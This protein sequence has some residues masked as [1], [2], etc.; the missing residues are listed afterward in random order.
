M[1]HIKSTY[2]GQYA[3]GSYVVQGH[4]SLQQ[5]TI[6]AVHE[7]HHGILRRSS[8]FGAIQKTAERFFARSEQSGSVF[9]LHLL[10]SNS[11]TSEEVHATYQSMRSALARGWNDQEAVFAMHPSYRMYY[12]IGT[13]LVGFEAQ[14]VVANAMLDAITRF[15]WSAAQLAEV[16]IPI[17]DVHSLKRINSASYPD[18][19][20]KALL[21]QWD[22]A[23]L[24]SIIGEA[25]DGDDEKLRLLLGQDPMSLANPLSQI[26]KEM[27]DNGMFVAAPD[28]MA[29]LYQYTHANL[30]MISLVTE[31]LVVN[32]YKA[33]TKRFRGTTLA[34]FEHDD[35]MR[36]VNQC[37][38]AEYRTPEAPSVTRFRN[39]PVTLH[40]RRGDL[41]YEGAAI[42]VRS[43][44]SFLRNFETSGSSLV[45]GDSSVVAY[46]PISITDAPTP[47]LE[48]IVNSDAVKAL[49]QFTTRWAVDS[50][51]I[52]VFASVIRK[53]PEVFWPLLDELANNRSY[54]WIVGDLPPRQCLQLIRSRAPN[55]RGFWHETTMP[56]VGGMVLPQVGEYGSIEGLIFLGRKPDV[57]GVILGIVI[58]ELGEDF[59]GFGPG[60][61]VQR[62]SRHRN[63]IGEQI[64][65]LLLALEQTS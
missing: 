59:R 39:H 56:N 61:L 55:M 32:A 30:M 33:L 52:V 34:S 35:L 20:L 7:E 65:S 48:A 5:G 42:L 8:A 2:M 11:R 6:A 41:P 46:A 13:K 60:P 9:A 15:C 63:E 28:F 57:T 1:S 27:G 49:S 45:I 16:E 24:D 50:P 36:F 40:S 58:D 25:M 51:V 21:Q 26:S 53:S 19:R 18:R 17:A 64:V 31:Q 47:Q 23:M 37:K 3:G 44:S 4:L 29:E 14:E 22:R 54:I 10:A 43:G 38:E 12:E 62:S